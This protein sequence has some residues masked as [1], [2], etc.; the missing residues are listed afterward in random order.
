MQNASR[1][2]TIS[3]TV[4]RNNRTETRSRAKDEL[5]KVIGA[6]DKTVARKWEKRWVMLKD[7]SISVWKWVP[8]SCPPGGVVAPKLITAQKAA[9]A[10]DE[11]GSANGTPTGQTAAAAAAVASADETTIQSGVSGENNSNEDT[12][13]VNMANGEE[14]G[15]D[16]NAAL[17]FSDIGAF[18]SD[19][20]T[21][22]RVDYGSSKNGR[23]GRAAADSAEKGKGTK[24]A[25]PTD[26]SQ[27]RKEEETKEAQQQ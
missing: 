11:N 5:R 18:D 19:S 16:S 15:D 7:S 20:Q 22:D 10:N 6:V 9:A 1:S 26:F 8:V 4:P 14:E 21:F 23:G 17:D 25:Q 12:G 13:D 3:K 24:V 27:M 2:S